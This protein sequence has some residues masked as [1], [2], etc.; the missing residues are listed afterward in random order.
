MQV[1]G[2]RAPKINDF[3][4]LPWV[5]FPLPFYHHQSL[6]IHYYAFS[7]PNF[8]FDVF[9]PYA[10]AFNSLYFLFQLRSSIIYILFLPNPFGP[11]LSSTAQC[12]RYSLCRM[13]PIQFSEQCSVKFF[14][15]PTTQHFFICYFI[16][17]LYLLYS[18]P[19]L[20]FKTLQTVFVGLSESPRL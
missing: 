18:S 4:F 15:L 16:Y 19:A 2:V 1:H 3:L 7:F 11:I 10:L 5:L 12:R 6:L 9:Q 17:L 14:L 20:R 8:F 13:G